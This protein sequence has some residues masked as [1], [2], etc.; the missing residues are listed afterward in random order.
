MVFGISVIGAPSALA[1]DASQ[2]GGTQATLGARLGN[3]EYLRFGFGGRL[4]YVFA[5]NIYFGGLFDYYL[6]TTQKADLTN[7]T[8]EVK[9][10]AWMLNLEL[11]YDF[12]VLEGMDVRAFG[13]LGNTNF[14]T[15]STYEPAPG[16]KNILKNN[17]LKDSKL[18]MSLGAL[19]NY[20]V[21]PLLLGPEARLVLI[22]AGDTAVTGGVH[23]GVA[24]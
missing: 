11:G 19:M 23:V 14:A 8:G 24:F 15:K 1:A 3:K 20:E 17:T 16:K 5:S 9:E 22:A 18:T 6:G 12:P 10:S 7:A 4:G 13:G 2:A 21:G